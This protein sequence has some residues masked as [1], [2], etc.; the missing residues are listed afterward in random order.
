MRMTIK[1][2]SCVGQPFDGPSAVFDEHGGA[3]GRRLDCTLVIPDKDRHVSRVHATI[4]F[5]GDY[6]AV[7]DRGS[8]L[9]VVVNGLRV[10]QGNE[11]PVF[12]GDLIEIGEFGLR[13]EHVET[14][15]DLSPDKREV[16]GSFTIPARVPVDHAGDAATVSE[17]GPAD[18]PDS[19]GPAGDA[20]AGARST[21]GR[22]KGAR[23]DHGTRAVGAGQDDPESTFEPR[24]GA[25][26]VE[27]VEQ[28]LSRLGEAI[29]STLK[30][31]EARPAGDDGKAAIP[32]R[33]GGR[34][35][36]ST[37]D[38]LADRLQAKD[39]FIE[40][41]M[42]SV[43][44]ELLGGHAAETAPSAAR[45]VGAGDDGGSAA[46]EA[47]PA[48]PA[49]PAGT[50]T[51]L[52][53]AEV[54]QDQGAAG[55]DAHAPDATSGAA[56]DPGTGP[57]VT[58]TIAAVEVVSATLATGDDVEVFERVVRRRRRGPRLSQTSGETRTERLSVAGADAS[59]A[60]DEP[61]ILLVMQPVSDASSPSDDPLS[62]DPAYVIPV[63][64]RNR[65][66]PPASSDPAHPS[67]Q[68][69]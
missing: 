30:V 57:D 66:A 43:W 28:I 18:P 52:Q 25:E 13:V 33:A 58:G 20:P 63:R 5:R 68:S 41:F 62:Q 61:E 42:P 48:V 15:W 4:A 47:A 31:P 2:V 27:E 34:A 60:R 23:Q 38:L 12:E 26:P 11:T 56:A 8:F 10:G 65:R 36:F 21:R 50:Q 6:F 53:A 69:A 39:E 16:F 67:R 14:A 37:F 59:G 35:S 51:D 22:R 9:P 24:A 46:A 49:D 7:V 44:D 32:G 54:G 3:I 40:P 19:S 29:T 17:A 64:R 55:P 45:P 1:L